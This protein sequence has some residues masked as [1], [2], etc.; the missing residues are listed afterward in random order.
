MT[1]AAGA[2]GRG[3]LCSCFPAEPIGPGRTGSDVTVSLSEAKELT[4][5][6]GLDA[7][8]VMTDSS[9]DFASFYA[10]HW[11][12][13]AGFMATLVG[14]TTV[15]DEL[16]QEA[17]VRL[18]PRFR[19]IR[20]P[21]PYVFRIGANLANRH[22]RRPRDEPLE[23]A[24][25]QVALATGLEPEVLDA[26]HRL[27]TRLRLVVLLHYFADL[28]VNDVAHALHRPVGSIKR[29]LSEARSLLASALGEPS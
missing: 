20:E 6:R 11:S 29:Q 13:L 14:S 7:L 25:E 10:E 2:V 19:L 15:G 27:P 9:Q 12:D 17:F 4:S 23:W 3:R 1:F 18:Y 28:P 16:T 8:A 26:V 22:R 21:R 24:P 5:A